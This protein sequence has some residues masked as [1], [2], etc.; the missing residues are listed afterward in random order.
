MENCR[1]TRRQGPP[2]LP[3]GEE[4]IQWN[5]LPYPS[6]IE[7]KHT[8]VLRLARRA[9]T[10]PNVSEKTVENS[11]ILQATNKQH[12]YTENTPRSGKI[13][14]KQLQINHNKHMTPKTGE[15]LPTE[16]K[17]VTDLEAM[18]E[19]TVAR[20]PTQGQIQHT[21]Q[22]EHTTNPDNNQQESPRQSLHGDSAQQYL[23]KKFSDVMRAS[24]LGSNIS[25]LFK[26]K[27][28]MSTYNEHKITL[29]WVLPDGKNRQLETLTDK[30]IADF[31]APGENTGAML[32]SLPDLEPFYNT[33]KFLIDLQSG[34]LFV[35][36]KG[37]WHPAGFLCKK[38]NFNVDQ[39]MPLIQH[40]TRKY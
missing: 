40:A 20:T 16:A 32:V 19:G 3:N 4:L 9:N 17:Q 22:S 33:R 27:T 18:E 6:R 15:I 31:P 34:D 35:M 21:S 5:S 36:L 29:D 26:A 2:S 37:K 10:P 11:E 7:R 39:L 30:H 28:F 24:A 23:D 13:S 14:P 38:N 1:R 12:Q 8:E 25:S